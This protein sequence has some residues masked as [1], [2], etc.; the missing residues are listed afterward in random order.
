MSALSITTS[1][2]A[3]PLTVVVGTYT[4]SGSRGVYTCRIDPAS[5]EVETLDS[6][7]VDN[8]SY[9]VVA[10]DGRPSTPWARTGRASHAS[11]P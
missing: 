5:L 6:V 2:A 8:P 10:P 9:L 3:T 11:T 1:A 4:G 7:Q